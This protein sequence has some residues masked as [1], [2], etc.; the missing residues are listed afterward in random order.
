MR[1]CVSFWIRFRIE[2]QT[3]TLCVRRWNNY[4]QPKTCRNWTQ[5]WLKLIQE[6]PTF[7][8][9]YIHILSFY[10]WCVA[11]RTRLLQQKFISVYAYL[12]ELVSL[13]RVYIC[14]CG[15]KIEV[16]SFF[17][18]HLFEFREE[19]EERKWNG[20]EWIESHRKRCSLIYSVSLKLLQHTIWS[21]STNEWFI[22]PIWKDDCFP[23]CI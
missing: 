20:M 8:I 12:P 15:D 21:S 16:N 5:I 11:F 23:S 18:N 6:K 17:F 19:A 14:V 22:L 9:L 7:N 3:L 2:M 13:T 10:L 1:R 4:R